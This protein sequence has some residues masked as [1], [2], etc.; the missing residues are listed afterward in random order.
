MSPWQSHETKK[1]RFG[2]LNLQSTQIYKQKSASDLV[3]AFLVPVEW[4]RSLVLWVF[5][6]ENSND[7]RLLIHIMTFRD[8]LKRDLFNITFRFP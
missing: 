4:K 8:W 5:V 3:L 1:T 7:T 6:T 2:S